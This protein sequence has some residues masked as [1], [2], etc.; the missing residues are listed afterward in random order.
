M[1]KAEYILLAEN[2]FHEITVVANG[3]K[4]ECETIMSQLID[5]GFPVSYE[6]REN[7]IRRSWDNPITGKH[8][9][10]YQDGYEETRPM[11]QT[12]IDAYTLGRFNL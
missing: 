2:N 7:T 6:I 12:E 5:K 9:D 1:K 10:L 4:Q 11:T 8:Y 3:S